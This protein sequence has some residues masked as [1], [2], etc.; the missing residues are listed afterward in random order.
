MTKIPIG[1]AV[2]EFRLK[3]AL[4]QEDLARKAKIK[5]DTLRALER[6]G[7]KTRLRTITLVAKA[8]ETTPQALDARARELTT[9]KHLEPPH[10]EEIETDLQLVRL[11]NFSRLVSNRTNVVRN[12]RGLPILTLGDNLYVKRDVE[13]GIIER[14]ATPD[15]GVGPIVIEGEPGT[16]KSSLLWSLRRTLAEKKLSAWLIDAIELMAIFGSGENGSGILSEAFRTP[17]RKLVELGRVPILLI[18]TADVI[19]NQRSKETYFESLLGELQEAGV[20]IVVASRPGEA[21]RL[22]ILDPFIAQ[23]FEYSENEF[24][25][26]VGVYARAYV[27]QGATVSAETH[28]DGLLDAAAQGFPIKE[29]CRNPLTLRMLYSIYA[30]EQ[31]NV[32]DIDVV[33]LYR[34]YWERRVAADIRTNAP[35]IKSDTEDA[36]QGAMLTAIAMLVEGVPEIQFSTL[37]QEFATMGVAAS[38]I[39]TLLSRGVLKDMHIEHERSVTFFHQTFFEHAAAM[40]LLR[41][42]GSKGPLA[43]FERWKQQQGNLFLGA[44][45]ERTLVL[46]EHEAH[47]IRKTCATIMTE[48][49]KHGAAGISVLA[50]AFVHRRSAPDV[51]GKLIEERVLADDG[52]VIERILSLSG[53]ATRHRRLSLIALLGH[54]IERKNSRWIR[55][56]MEL[57]LRFSTLDIKEVASVMISQAAPILGADNDAYPQA[58]TLFLEFLSRYYQHDQDWALR[59]M[60]RQLSD[61]LSRGSDVAA[62]EVLE[63]ISARCRAY[64]RLTETIESGITERG[65]NKTSG[66]LSELLGNLFYEEWKSS[67]QTPVRIIEN[68]NSSPLPWGLS[69]AARLN[70]LSMLLCDGDPS[71]AVDAFHASTAVDDPMT[72]VMLGRITWSRFLSS[73]YENWSRDDSAIVV[74]RIRTLGKGAFEQERSRAGELVFHMIQGGV[75]LELAKQLLGELE[76]D[77]PT[78]WLKITSLGR[79]LIRGVAAKI[80]GAETAFAELLEKPSAYGPLPHAA[81]TQIRNSTFNEDSLA[82]GME[83]ALRISDSESVLDLLTKAHSVVGWHEL[84]GRISGLISKLR[85][86]GNVRLRRQAV[87]IEYEMVRLKLD[88]AIDWNHLSKHAELESDDINLAFIVRSLGFCIE[89]DTDHTAD[90][91]SWLASFSADK[92]TETRTATI[93]TFGQLYQKHPELIVRF[94]DQLFDLAFSGQPD[95]NI[96]KSLSNPVFVLYQVRDPRVMELAETL[97]RRSKFLPMQTCRRISGTFRRLFGMIMQRMNSGDRKRLLSEVPGLN[98][99]LARMIVEGFA[100][101]ESNLAVQFQP[102]IENPQTTPE[103]VALASRFVRRE[104]RASGLERWPELYELLR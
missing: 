92:G 83:L 13:N 87:H 49:P 3:C 88:P 101:S 20:R 85:K 33:S 27:R 94:I 37:G 59:E 73:I 84:V 90:R 79:Y 104:L 15:H 98:R 86:D 44:V 17:F 28:A 91:L 50:Y 52:L 53:N 61:A 11:Q 72:R 2:E 22:H 82:I 100:V 65:R 25:A 45:L 43:L 1:P 71:R 77:D 67:L 34:A 55:R 70:G 57:L 41:L 46:S 8:L 66:G 69:L 18:D 74:G 26:A 29:I 32:A 89:R 10:I 56:A 96:L 58:R 64:P 68:L 103:I 99:Y 54:I 24:I 40:A 48:L 75:S 38:S 39:S 95:G 62:M 21:M 14:L 81:L 60:V 30:P 93:E 102:I 97:I 78:P 19:L 47:P 12:E 9:A 4:T 42:A 63:V 76:L 7:S 31:I 51:V 16:G 6:D 36:S 80:N 5:T 23:L 35:T